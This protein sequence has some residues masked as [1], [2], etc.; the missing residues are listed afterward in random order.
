MR[1]NPADHPIDSS[2]NTS[3]ANLDKNVHTLRDSSRGSVASEQIATGGIDNFSLS[4][5]NT[6]VVHRPHNN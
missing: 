2:S 3:I 5:M 6:L 1:L 4:E